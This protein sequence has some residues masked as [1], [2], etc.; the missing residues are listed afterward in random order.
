MVG[1]E[2][3]TCLRLTFADNSNGTLNPSVY[4]PLSSGYYLIVAAA[5]EVGGKAIV[6]LKEAGSAPELI[7]NGR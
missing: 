1:A 3:N 4:I 7:D 2:E 6:F 5:F